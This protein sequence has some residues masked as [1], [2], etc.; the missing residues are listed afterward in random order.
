M[1]IIVL[2]SYLSPYTLRVLIE[3]EELGVDYELKLVNLK[4]GE[5]RTPEFLKMQVLCSDCSTLPP[6][7]GMNST[8]RIFFTSSIQIWLCQSDPTSRFFHNLCVQF[9]VRAFLNKL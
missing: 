7:L 2:G 9:M 6:C 3:L 4:Q 8:S 5:H 1:G